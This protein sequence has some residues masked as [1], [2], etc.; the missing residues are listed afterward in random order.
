MMDI[1]FIVT[2]NRKLSR[3]QKGRGFLEVTVVSIRYG[4]AFAMRVPKTRLR[5]DGEF[6]RAWG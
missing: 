3:R 6:E 1:V 5:A 4:S 2:M